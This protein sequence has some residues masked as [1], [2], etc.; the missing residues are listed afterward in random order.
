MPIR[1]SSFPKWNSLQRKHYTVQVHILWT[2]TKSFVYCDLIAWCLF[3]LLALI[4][5]L[6]LCI[7]TF[8]YCCREAHYSIKHRAQSIATIFW[9]LLYH[10][11]VTFWNLQWQMLPLINSVSECS[12]VKVTSHQ[13]VLL[14]LPWKMT[15]YIIE[16][17]VCI[18]SINGI[19]HP[20][21]K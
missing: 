2:V 21:V 1:V 16:D 20:Q 12:K 5:K 17:Y 9:L 8:S 18:W 4:A 7:Y 6:H 19:D 13:T 15:I 11:T 3:V 14:Q 10:N